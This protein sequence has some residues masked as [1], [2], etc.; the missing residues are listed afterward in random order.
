VRQSWSDSTG[1]FKQVVTTTQSG[2]TAA[3]TTAGGTAGVIVVATFSAAANAVAST[4]NALFL[5]P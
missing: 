2:V 4:F 5:G 1:I 3:G